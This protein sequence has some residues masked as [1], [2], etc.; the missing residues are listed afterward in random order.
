MLSYRGHGYY[1]FNFSIINIEIRPLI[2]NGRTGRPPMH[3][4]MDAQNYFGGEE[5]QGDAQYVRGPATAT[6]QRQLADRV[7]LK[8]RRVDQEF[9]RT[10]SS[11]AYAS[12]PMDAFERKVSP[13]YMLPS[14]KLHN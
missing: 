4:C 7:H 13:I 3:Q 9:G 1:R 8:W 5:N 14:P 2:S 11:L 12:S 6:T 10:R